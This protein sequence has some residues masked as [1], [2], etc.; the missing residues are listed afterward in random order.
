MDRE[1]LVSRFFPQSV[2]FSWELAKEEGTLN[3]FDAIAF[4]LFFFGAA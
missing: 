1:V 4:F 3:G 2:F